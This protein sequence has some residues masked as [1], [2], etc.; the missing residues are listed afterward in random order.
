MGF[1]RCRPLLTP[2]CVL[3]GRGCLSLIRPDSKTYS[4]NGILQ[5]KR[6]GY[7]NFLHQKAF[8]YSQIKSFKKTHLMTAFTYSFVR[9]LFYYIL[10]KKK[11]YYISC[12]KNY[13]I[14]TITFDTLIS[15]VN[16][17]S[18]FCRHIKIYPNT[19]FIYNSG[20]QQLQIPS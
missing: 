6:K 20:I 17:Q 5:I 19:T 16:Y 1:V 7:I 12:K 14:F 8:V 3:Q 10:N 11:F 18:R 9:Y 4:A 15:I 13:I 2:Q